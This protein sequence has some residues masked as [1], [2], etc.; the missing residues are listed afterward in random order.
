M[1]RSENEV[2]MDELIG[3]AVLSLLKTNGPITTQSL[4]MTLKAMEGVERDA[5]RRELLAA[6][7][8]EID[9][10]SPK[11]SGMQSAEN[12][13]ENGKRVF[14]LFNAA[15]MRNGGKIH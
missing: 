14:P 7:I 8:S 3:E 9:A 4:L 15:A 13:G 12:S 1:N 2:V 5:G 6:I 11:E 10:V